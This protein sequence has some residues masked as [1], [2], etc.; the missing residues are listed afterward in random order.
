MMNKNALIVILTIILL[1]GVAAIVVLLQSEQTAAP[2]A[3][4]QVPDDM[5]G[6]FT[7]TD[8]DGKQ[9]STESFKGKYKLIYFGFT[10][11]PAICPTEL[12]KMSKAIFALNDEQAARVQ[13]IFVTVDPDRDTVAVLK[14][15]VGLFSMNL[16]GFTGTNE[17]IEK[18]KRQFRIYAAKVDD[19]NASEYTVD[20]SSYIYLLDPADKVIGLFNADDGA[21]KITAELQKHL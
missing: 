8:Q 21:E 6:P 4:L 18:I 19:P 5:G 1:C 14:D 15:Y 16:V 10:H 13:P 17:E 11:C 9:T 3:T 2:A 12:Q 20:H 7:L